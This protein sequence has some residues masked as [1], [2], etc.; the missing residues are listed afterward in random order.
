[1]VVWSP[2]L[3]LELPL[4]VEA[5][6][7]G[8]EIVGDI[9]LFAR[10]A[11]APVLAVTG[12]NGKSTVTALTAYLLAAAGCSAPAGGNLGPPAL[13]LLELD[14]GVQ[15]ADAYV[16]EISS[17]QMEATESL[18]PLAAALLNLSADHLDRHGDLD[19]YAALKAKLISAAEYAVFNR[20]DPHVRTLGER[21]ARPV[22]FS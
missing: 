15:S 4:A 9:E 19:R 10:A 5:R 17:F 6:R 18:R 14:G 1:R 8:I 20:D 3:S 7:R 11:N 2:G 16:L 13:E 12:S 22:P 21:A